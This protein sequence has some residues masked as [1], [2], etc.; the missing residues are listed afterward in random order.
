MMSIDPKKWGEKTIF[1]NTNVL[2]VRHAEKPGN[3]GSDDAKDGPNLSPAGWDRA[4]AYVSYFGEFTARSVGG[5][6]RSKPLRVDQVFAAADDY[7]TSYR[8]RLTVSLFADISSGPRPLSACIADEN[9]ADLVTQLESEDYDGRNILVCWHHG[10]IINLANALLTS[11]GK[12]MMPVLRSGACWPP[13]DAKWPPA[14]FGWLFQI[15]FD[16]DGNPDTNW[17]RCL[18]EKLMPDDTGDP[19]NGWLTSDS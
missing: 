16:A 1:T 2:L 4:A 13:Q 17:T 10:Q 3:P 6:N 19:C 14:V 8:P 15:C 9:Y 18:N 5:S 12:R 11:N 7:H